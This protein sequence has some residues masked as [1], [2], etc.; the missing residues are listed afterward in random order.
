MNPEIQVGIIGDFDPQKYF[1]HI[2]T[3]EA[4]KHAGNAL[5]ASVNFD[6]LPTLSLAS[7]GGEITLRKFDALWCA[8]G[9]PY[10]RPCKCPPFFCDLRGFSTCSGRVCTERNGYRGRRPRRDL[11]QCAGI[12]H[13][14]TPFIS[15][16]NVTSHKNNS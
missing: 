2:A 1:S 12:D 13:Q 5:S 10:F 4:L 8:P 11:S 6:W 7:Q 15:C 3:N 9:S 14:Q 16:W